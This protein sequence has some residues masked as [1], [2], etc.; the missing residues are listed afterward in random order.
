MVL[1]PSNLAV[2]IENMDLQ[3]FLD[4]PQLDAEMPDTEVPSS[5]N[6]KRA[7]RKAK[8]QGHPP[9]IGDAATKHI[10]KNYV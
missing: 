4:D 7:S 6:S 5:S 9:H 10:N 1:G 3:D 8:T 2:D